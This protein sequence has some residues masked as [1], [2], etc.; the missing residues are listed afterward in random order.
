M[1][2]DTISDHIIA[3]KLGMDVTGVIKLNRVHYYDGMRVQ[4]PH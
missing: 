1:A 4:F 2:K 3:G